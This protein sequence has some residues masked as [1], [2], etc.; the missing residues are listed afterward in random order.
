MPTVPSYDTAQVAPA[1]VPNAQIQGLTPRQLAQGE[2][3]GQQTELAGQN[4]LNL[5]VQDVD[6]NAKA[7]MMANQ[8]RVD[9]ALNNVRAAQQKLTY[10]PETGYLNQKGAAAVQPNDQGQGLQDQYGAKL[11]DAIGSASDGLANG[12]QRQVFARSASQLST[13]FDGQI[14]SHVLQEYKQFGLET[15]QG[16]VALAGDTAQKNW[17]NPDIIDQQI[18]SAK[19]A[20][21]KAGQI[22]GD[23]GNLIEAKTLQTTSGIHSGV[24]N[25]AVQNNNPQYA[26]QYIQKYK[27][28]MTAGDLLKAQGVITADMRAR[29][30]TSMALNAMT[31]Y[32]PAF[33]PTDFDR[34]TQITR[35]AESTNN[36]NAVGPNVP[37]QGTAKGAMQV[38]DATAANPGHGIAP[39]NPGVPGDKERVGV[40]LLGALVQKYAG[41]PAKAWAAYNAGEGNVDKA[42][43]DAGPGGN[44]MTALAQYQSPAN[45]TQTLNY[46]NSNVKQLQSGGGVPPMPSL[47]D[48]HNNIRTQAGP[49]A[50]PSVLSAALTEGTRQYN[51]AVKDRSTQADNAVQQAQTYLAQNGGNFDALPASMKSQIVA[52]AP[53]KLPGLQ[54]YAQ[55]IANP[56]KTDNMAAYHTAIEHP[57]ELAK[58]TDAQFQQFATTNFAEATQKQVAKIRQ[59]E[60]NGT[61]DLS[62]GGLNSKALTTELGNRLTSLG[63]ETKPKDEAGKQQ[64]GT[65]Q[66]FVTDG[67]FAQQQQLGRKMTAQEV[68]QF[69]DQQFLKNFQFHSTFMGIPTSGTQQTPY[70]KMA[71]GDIPGDQLDQVKAA[72]AKNGNTNPSNDQIMRTYWAR[73]TQ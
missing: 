46:V 27:D 14:Q 33:Q 65:I 28:D 6:A 23:P 19:A 45:H 7:Q 63:I 52:L 5:G 39:E 31:N 71:T 64:I 54:T 26:Q 50:D 15:Q 55:S 60:I 40:Q 43:K 11:Q 48:I 59:D 17:Q 12:A 53:D 29:Q 68:T 18:E 56:P 21:W 44:W 2:I 70:L 16:T 1:G 38:M 69:V 58:M 62:A 34:I 4:A 30:S 25:A 35:Q 41:D 73:K 66:K 10:D 67:I 37:G 57:D 32:A 72:L 22:N 3:S 24:I 36:P 9:A 8:V 42:V 61:A 47:Q 20:V 13:Q 49:N 51:D